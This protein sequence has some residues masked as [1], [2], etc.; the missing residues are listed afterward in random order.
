MKG[1]QQQQLGTLRASVTAA[2]RWLRAQLVALRRDARFPRCLAL[3]LTYLFLIGF[4]GDG[5][6][7]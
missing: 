7:T 6:D 4:K 2:K 1:M 3:I 5:T